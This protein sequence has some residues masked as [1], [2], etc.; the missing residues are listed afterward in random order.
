[1]NRTKYARHRSIM[2]G[3]KNQL[4]AVLKELEGKA[5][6]Y[7]E[8]EASH[9]L[10]TGT[11]CLDPRFAMDQ[12]WGASNFSL[13]PTSFGSVPDYKGVGGKLKIDKVPEPLRSG[14]QRI[15]SEVVWI[16]TTGFQGSTVDGL[17]VVAHTN[18][19][20]DVIVSKWG[21]GDNLKLTHHF[22]HWHVKAKDS[23]LKSHPVAY[24]D[25]FNPDSLDVTPPG[26]KGLTDTEMLDMVF[27]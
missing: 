2:K 16:L 10:R 23:K 27:G 11:G 20:F 26:R 18:E 7:Q 4:A 1:M 3:Q 22:Y 13:K 21:R 24:V 14:V 9:D 25:D 6:Y 8:Y 12:E 19:F 15:W 17:I 5:K